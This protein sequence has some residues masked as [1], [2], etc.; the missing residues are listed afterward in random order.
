MAGFKA[1]AG[2]AMALALSFGLAG[3]ASS[4]TRPVSPY[5]LG[6]YSQAEVLEFISKGL[7]LSHRGGVPSGKD[8]LCAISREI[9]RNANNPKYS[10][11]MSNPQ[12]RTCRLVNLRWERAILIFGSLT[13]YRPEYLKLEPADLCVITG[14]AD[15]L[16]MD[17]LTSR[18][19]GG[20]AVRTAY[21]G[22]RDFLLDIK[23]AK[24]GRYSQEL[25]E[26]IW[27]HYS[28]LLSDIVI[29]GS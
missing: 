26:F 22:Q 23:C 20:D 16:F 1:V 14:M 5:K 11:Y 19:P 29:F 25:D 8:A 17:H 10:T 9:M 7:E 21:R 27:G 15:Y 6:T 2:I 18:P 24:L 4:Q 28:D 12:L 3:T 13:E